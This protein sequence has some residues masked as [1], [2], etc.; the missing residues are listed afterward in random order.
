M[1]VGSLFVKLR[2]YGIFDKETFWAEAYCRDIGLFSRDEQLR[3]ADAR[4]ALP[5]MGGVGGVHM[6]TLARAGVGKFNI[7]DLDV[8]EIANINRQY[9]ASIPSLGRP[10]IDVM[11]EEA[12]TINPF[13]DIKMFPQGI[14]ASNVDEFL[15]DVDVVL[16]GIDFFAYPIRRLIFNRAKKRG[17][18]VVTA[19]PLG[20]STALLI[21][22]PDGM[23]FDEYFDVDDATPLRE[24]LI[25]FA[26]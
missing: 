8:Y 2:S 13:L 7:S 11:A 19:G 23:S 20:F 9:G 4:V 25:R 26:L 10:K 12:L 21:F 24:C 18:P 22:T 14:S 5:G 3:L 17:I 15:E 1:D 6:V 16:D